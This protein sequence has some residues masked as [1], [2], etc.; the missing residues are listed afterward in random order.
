MN[1]GRRRDGGKGG[2]AKYWLLGGFAFVL[3]FVVVWLP[4][5]NGPHLWLGIPSI[6]WWTCVPGSLLIT[7]LLLAFQRWQERDHPD[8]DEEDGQ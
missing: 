1:P 4:Q 2:R 3:S 5:I 7:P 8:I 6:L